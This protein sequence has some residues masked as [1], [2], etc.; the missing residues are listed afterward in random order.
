M[1]LAPSQ[2][3]PFPLR[4]GIATNPATAINANI[5]IAQAPL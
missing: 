1:S 5:G 2:R 4:S 3:S